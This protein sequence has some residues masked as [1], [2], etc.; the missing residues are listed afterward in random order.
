[1]GD[2]HQMVVHNVG[3]MISRQ[4]IGALIEH[5]IV[6]D[7]TLHTHIATNEVIHVNLLT[8]LHL[9]THGVL[10]VAVQQL[11]YLFLRQGKRVAHLHTTAGIVLEVGHLL[12]LL[13]Q[14]LRCV[15]SQ[16]GLVAVEQLLHVALVYLATLALT[17]RAVLAPK[18]YA[19]VKFDTQPG[20]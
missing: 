13:G 17:V 12:T 11:V 9:K 10:R 6:E 14:F 20:E 7:V 15:K 3:K 18:A 1:M 16:I 19:F 4:L 2:F 5:L 8:R